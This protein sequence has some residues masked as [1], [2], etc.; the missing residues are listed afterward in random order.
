M[1]T[2]HSLLVFVFTLLAI[3]RVEA[4]FT[5]QGFNYQC[6]VRDANGSSLNNQTVVL[7]F[8][9]RSGAPNGAV[10]Y[11]EKQ[12]SST[13][14]FGL[15]NL[16]IGQ[17]TALQGAFTSINWGNSA[18]FLTVSVETAPNVFDELGSTQL[19]SV[20]YA[21]YAEK[22]ADSGDDWG[23]QTVQTSPILS[24]TGTAGSP[25]TLAPQGAQP[26]QILKWNGTTWL[27]QDDNTGQS[28]T[29][30]EINTGAGL[31]GGP[32]TTAGT[33]ELANTPVTPGV[34]GSSTQIPVITVDQQGRVTD[35]VTVVPQ[36]STIGITGA[37]GIAVQ[38]NGVNFVL[39]N[40]GDTDASDDLLNTS[41]A[42]GDVSGPFSN[43]QIKANVVGNP[44]L[45]DNAVNTAKIADNAVSSTKIINQAVSTEKLADQAVTGG[46]IDAMGAASGQVL[47]WNGTTWAPATD[48]AGTFSVTAG[49][50]INVT[51]A[52]PNFTIN[53][54]GDTNPADDITAASQADGDVSGPFANLQLKPN[55]V[56]ATEL[57]NN[58]VTNTKIN[59][60]AVT[61]DK[62][63]QMSASNGQVLKWNGTTWAPAADIAGTVTINGGIGI[64]VI[65]S[66]T[67]N[68]TIANNGDVNP[69][70]DVTETSVAGGDLSGPFSNLQIKQNI[71][72][73]FEMAN[74]AIATNNLQNNA[75]TGAKLSQMGALTGQVLEWNGLSWAP[76]T[77]DIGSIG[78]NWGIQVALTGATLSGNGVTGSPLNIAQQGA[79]S[80]QV[81]K[82]NGTTWLPANDNNTG[83]D[84][85]G[86]QV[87]ITN[88]SIDGEGTAGNPLRVAQQGA[89]NGKVLKWN[90]SFWAPGDD[91]S[92]S[93]NWGTQVT[94]TNTTLSGDGTAAN[95]LGL[96]QQG[97]TNG[98]VLKWN[99][100]TW[101]PADDND[102]GG[103]DWGV[104]VAQ[105]NA[106]LVGNGT[107]ANKLG[108]A[109]QGANSGQVLKWN[110]AS[111]APA[112]DNTGSGP[113]DNWGT[114]VVETSTEFIGEGTTVSPLELASQG[115]SFG[116]VLKWQG[117][118]WGPSDDENT[119]DN[120]GV[121]SVETSNQ[122]SGN[123]TL[124][125]P[126]TLAAQG[127]A[128][129]QVLKWTGS[130]WAP[131]NDLV[132]G[133]GGNSYT[134][135]TGI[136]ITGT[137]PN[138]VINNSGDLSNTNE[139]Q[140]ISLSGNNLT[141]SNG[142]GTV[143]LPGGNTY[144][145]GTGINITGAAP[146]FT[147]VNTGDA[148]A[149][150]NNELQA[151]SLAGNNLT[152][153]NGGGT[154]VL[155]GG[156]TYSAGAG[157][158]ITGSAPN[159]TI[160]NT[161][162]ADANSTNELQKLTLNGT[163]LKLS[164]T[165]TEVNLDTVLTNAGVN[166]WT[167][168]GANIHNSNTGNVGVGTNLPAAKLHVKGNGE[169]LR[170][171]GANPLIGFVN[172]NGSDYNGF[173]GQS[174]GFLVLGSQDSSTIVLSSGNGKA[175]I[176]DG[177][178][179]NV[180]IGGQNI[181]DARLKVLHGTG[182]P[183]LMVENSDVGFN[184]NFQ[185]NGG[186][187][188][189]MLFNN[190]FGGGFPAG[191]FAT[192]GLYTPSDRRLKKDIQQL[193]EVLAK[194][195]QLNAVQYR[196]TPEKSNA[197]LSIGFLAQDVQALFPELVTENKLTDGNTYLGLNYAG[198][199]VLAVKAVQEQQ[200]QIDQLQQENKNLR[201][202]L[203]RLELA[204]RQLELP[205]AGTGKK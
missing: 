119:G 47:K 144:N 31:T 184:W 126:L 38:Q 15:V 11:S 89:T 99:G 143:A 179:G 181:N 33:I 20:P 154:V 194:M 172:G 61:A 205:T 147:I 177:T 80:G 189:L 196:Y 96:A 160:V 93:D 180:G 44:E 104:Q 75:V 203:N 106:T 32:I 45:A 112:D 91:N 129:G 87:V 46:K 73:N 120:W 13:N 190:T 192:T 100:S 30:T 137:A 18:K 139:L 185:V 198:F 59:A 68:F 193:P 83:A 131:S 163:K 63:A 37:S 22:S 168:V 79:S 171:Q 9:I 98:K 16:V 135:G 142:G 148:D 127:A 72:S 5:P 110:G 175:V 152:L 156:N 114:Q 64:D 169:A 178:T 200:T 149:N 188:N 170:L 102:S 69:F 94:E 201:E 116:Q 6:I 86:T 19:M 48:V 167:G 182:N 136:N 27:P 197:N 23:A 95:K 173:L 176:V 8:T 121:Q 39:T 77:D 141:L 151:L 111:W 101:A 49:T 58:A 3:W 21:L 56:T 7:L 53:N 42:N 35:V 36:P 117:T 70:D 140:S 76:A 157:I 50:G 4:Q 81:L 113:A 41:Q 29:I 130:T 71:I 158:N 88:P 97:A 124:I 2:R 161:G 174:D 123:G 107:T 115:A 10:S 34:Y 199:G 145:P 82:W 166:L 195:R 187:G 60:G 164:I 108:I 25:L 155:P 125:S 67:N 74:N 153:S 92:G 51:G 183:G 146:N 191:V 52:S 133:S 202:R 122:F 165:N 84:N 40:T 103:D 54:T 85:W 118:F 28:G 24:G 66:G 26:G 55:V 17:G 132:G 134:A 12:T 105:T 57:N 204:V 128:A 90:G 159:F 14:E 1:T 65:P 186:N 62:L 43:L 150:P 78:D 162:D 109:Q 138:L